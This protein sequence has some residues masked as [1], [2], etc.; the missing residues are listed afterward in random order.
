MS[1]SVVQLQLDAYLSTREALGFHMRA[2]RT[3]LREFVH[4]VASPTGLVCPSE[5]LS[6]LNGPVPSRNGEVQGGPRNV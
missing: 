4:F 6:R 3:L 5:P 2:E 1:P